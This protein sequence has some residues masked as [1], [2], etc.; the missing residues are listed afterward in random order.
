M[1]PPGQRMET[2]LIPVGVVVPVT[3]PIVAVTPA[4]IATIR[5]PFAPEEGLRVLTKFFPHGGMI[6]QEFIQPGLVL[7][8]LLILNQSRILIELLLN[9]GMIVE[10]T[11]EISELLAGSVFV[12]AGQ[13]PRGRRRDR[14]R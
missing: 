11:V 12:T 4:I 14:K 6:L 7:T 5:P 8:P 9:A 13:S 2:A 1:P 3:P 10:V